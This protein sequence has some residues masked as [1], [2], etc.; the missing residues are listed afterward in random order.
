[1]GI[2]E[3]RKPYGDRP[4]ES[5]VIARAEVLRA[6]GISWD[7]TAQQL[8]GEGV[9][10]RYG[11]AWFG[12][13]YARLWVEAKLISHDE[14]SIHSLCD[15]GMLLT[16][17]KLDNVLYLA[18]LPQIVVSGPSFGRTEQILTLVPDKNFA[19][20]FFADE[21]DTWMQVFKNRESYFVGNHVTGYD[22]ATEPIGDGRLYVKVIQ[23]VS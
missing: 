4:G 12:L 21:V 10:T 14:Q 7:A 20:A 13:R 3:G 9:S 18:V 1:M 11:G 16:M 6:S 5:E 22:Y 19:S 2:Y 23:H 17:T 8:N 15:S